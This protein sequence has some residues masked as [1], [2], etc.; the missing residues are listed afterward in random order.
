[1]SFQRGFVVLFVVALAALVW[2]SPALAQPGP[3]PG[4]PGAMMAQP[5]GGM[6]NNPIMLLMNPQVA[7]ELELS[8]DQQQK[9]RQLREELMGGMREQFEGFRDMSREEREARMR[10][11]RTKAEQRIQTAQTKVKEILLPHQVKRLEQISFQMQ[12]RRGISGILDNQEMVKKFGLTDKQIEDLKK[13]A[14][15]AREKL[16]KVPQ[17]IREEA[18]AKAKA[19]L[20]PAQLKLMEEAQGER[21][22][23]DFSRMGPGRRGERGGA[24]KP[25]P[26]P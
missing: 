24:D 6:F 20:T 3:G 25:E 1:M 13:I 12:T 21:F 11:L 22:E 10:E 16:Q 17:Q 5:G 7:E 8:E 23:L 18:E 14:E 9:F 19:I 15:E 26:K 4:G 2:A